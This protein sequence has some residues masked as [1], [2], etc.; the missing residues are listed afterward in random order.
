MNSYFTGS[1]LR[2]GNET[3]L[4]MDDTIIE[5]RWRLR[6]VLHQPDKH[7]RN[8]VIVRDKPWEGDTTQGAQVIWDEE[9][10][11]YRMWYLGCYISTYYYGSGPVILVCYAESE[12][13]FNWVKPLTDRFPVGKHK[14]TNVV[15]CGI[16]DQG[17]YYFTDDPEAYSTRLQNGNMSQVFK[18]M[19]DPDPSRR[20]K[21][22]S[23]EG[24]P[25]PTIREIHT[26]VSLLVSPDGFHWK[27]SGDRHI[28]DHS[29]D[30]LNHLVR[31]DAND[32]W[33]LYCRPPVFH[34]G[35]HDPLRNT[36]RR[37]AVMT[38]RDLVEWSYPHVVMY[39]DEHDTPDYDHVKV[40]RCGNIFIMMYSAMEGD[41]TGRWEIRLA[42][43][44][45]GFH[46]ERI[47]TRETWLGR[48]LPGSWDAG[49]ILPSTTPV[50]QG[51]RLLLYYSG[52][53]RGQ[54]EQGD[55]AAGIG[56]ATIRLDRFVE[57][58]ADREPGYLLTKE[59]ILEG[60]TLCVNME[61]N[62]STNLPERPSL[63]AEI[64]RHPPFGKHWEFNEACEGFSFDDCDP[65]CIDHTDATVTWKGKKDL[66]SL[67][68][69]PVY[70]RFELVYAGLF[71]FRIAKD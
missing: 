25:H 19:N 15:H 69:K 53:L 65:M 44:P 52:M 21:M 29:S 13:G 59:F 18:D 66:S 26:G 24:R 56:L 54:E 46:W 35:R 45:D 48:G 11:L 68:G 30:C 9:L 71:S 2:I 38:S 61:I 33:L 10:G 43:S 42:S 62:K 51:E 55:C 3:Q 20:Y 60:K 4:L 1:P 57:Q 36:R 50:Q 31:D 70:I 63:R 58:R 40:F 28:L 39:P 47:H 14:K 34:C 17:T 32:R 64:L 27:L 22:I 8:P 5:D 7:P 49:G 23:T 67:A 37:V 16:H 12:D 6:R 41:T